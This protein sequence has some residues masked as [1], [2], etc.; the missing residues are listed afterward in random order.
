MVVRFERTFLEARGE[1][2][3]S[4]EKVLGGGETWGLGGDGFEEGV[5]FGF[6]IVKLLVEDG[7]HDDGGAGAS[8]G[9]PGRL[10]A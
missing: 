9:Q 4:V 6:D 5:E 10:S 1:G 2:G 3:I 8:T 7:V